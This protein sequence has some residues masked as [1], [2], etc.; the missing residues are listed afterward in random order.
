LIFKIHI[1]ILKQIIYLTIFSTILRAIG[2]AKRAIGKAT[3]Q[4][5]I[6][7]SNHI[8]KKFGVKPIA[9][10]VK[11]SDIKKDIILAIIA[12]NK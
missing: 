4:A 10:K 12:T 11:I 7:D 3:I 1:F 2:S 9:R 5:I 8:L 6:N